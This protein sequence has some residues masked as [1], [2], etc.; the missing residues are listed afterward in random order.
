MVVN[1]FS[2]NKKTFD[3]GMFCFANTSHRCRFI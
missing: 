1:G 3:M 2:Q